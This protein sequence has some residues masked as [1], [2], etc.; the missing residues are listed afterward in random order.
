M[1]ESTG[2]KAE[3][4]KSMEFTESESLTLRNPDLVGAGAVR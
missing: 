1:K 2:V 4:T 3:D